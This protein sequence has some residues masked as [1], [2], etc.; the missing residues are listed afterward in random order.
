[1]IVTGLESVGKGREKVF[2][3]GSA[4]FVLYGGE[5][6][7]YGIR[8]DIEVSE[9]LYERILKEVL[10]KRAQAR[11]LYIL[12]S[13]DKTEAQM[14][15]KL[16]E[17]TY[18]EKVIE[19]VI[20]WLYGF[21]YLDDRRYAE[22]YVSQKKSSKSRKQMMLD[23]ERRGISKTLAEEVLESEEEEDETAL[24]RQWMEKK[25]VDPG[26]KDPKERQK[27][28]QFLARKGFRSEDI[29]RAFQV[30]NEWQ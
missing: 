10:L 29:R 20:G 22:N 1:M 5:L 12:K 3:D 26:T 13:M 9:E 6:S 21:H 14:R 30:E 4:A 2:L 11:S 7:R 8:E 16:K 25:H 17:G 28:W 15:Q 19:E 24:I 18:P 27:M 23:L